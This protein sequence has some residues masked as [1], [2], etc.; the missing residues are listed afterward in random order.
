MIYA[1]LGRL[2]RNARLSILAAWVLLLVGTHY[3]APAWSDIAKDQEFAF[4]PDDAPSRLADDVFAKAFPDDRTGSN[5]VLVLSRPAG[6]QGHTA[7]DRKFIDDVV[8]PGLRSIAD[9]EGGLAGEEAPSDEPLFGGD[10]PDQPKQPPAKRSIIRHIH[11]PNA[12]GSGSLLVSRDG[13]SLL[14]VMEL[15]SEFLSKGNWP[16][17]ARVEQFVTDLHANGKPPPGLDIHLTGSAVV[18]RDHTVAE[19][20]S[21]KA[22][23]NLT[24]LLVVGLLILIY[25][26]PLL[27]VIPL[28]TVYLAVQISRNLLALLGEAGIVTPFLGLEIYITILAYGAGVDY[29]LF[30]T[31]RFQEELGHGADEGE[32]VE[33]AVAGVGSALVASAATVMCGIGMMAFAEFGKFRQAGIAIPLALFV[34]LC[35]TLTFSPALLRLAGR[36]AYWPRH[37]PT[38][39]ESP[40][41]D[42]LQRV[43][44]GTGELLVRR[45]GTVWVVAFVALVPAA[46]AGGFYANRLSYDLVG[47]LR[48]DAP[49]VAGTRALQEHFPAGMVGPVTVLV[50]NPNADFATEGG[51]SLVKRLTARLIEE[52]QDLG[53]ADVRSLTSPLGAASP[54]EPPGDPDVPI[55]TRREAERKVAAEHY[56]TD[57]GERKK[58]GTRLELV[59]DE[60][61]FSHSNVDNLDRVEGAVRDALP[62]GLRQGSQLYF[63]GPTPGVR[64]LANV[65]LG[66]R[67]RIQLLVM[68]SVF[69]I[70]IVLLRGFVVPLYLLL[71]VLFSYYATLGVSFLVF[72]AIDPHGFTGID[73]KVGVFLFTILIAVGED[74]NIFLLTRVREEQVR[75]GNVCGIAEAVSRTGPVISSC[76]VIMAGTFASLTAGSLTE[77][78]Q[79]GFALAFGVLLDTFVVRPVLVPAFL[80]LLHTG[81]LRW[82]GRMPQENCSEAALTQ[83]PSPIAT[84]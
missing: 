68:A 57:F 17:V 50:V 58:I 67:G 59:F 41:V 8:E 53:L 30:L 23:E 14:V 76:G 44:E 83:R 21:A 18:G 46:V 12:P 13:R 81:R 38:P 1:F 16:T 60:G 61:P 22:T 10:E 63:V 62:D 7:A 64:D 33:R 24:V 37:P 82:Q 34:V 15:T 29:C 39:V 35:A 78:M 56:V 2:V 71:S 4:L 5:I 28:L 43:W 45:A 3:A 27:A 70:L 54:G 79:L 6:G 65:S 19:L 74:Y 52:K 31:A 55:E 36:W 25:R 26:A 48:D 51:R 72:R 75:H 32:A 49:S 11:T 80:I 66:D 47:N 40:K 77:L 42:W 73:W 84:H 69:L 9:S 20:R